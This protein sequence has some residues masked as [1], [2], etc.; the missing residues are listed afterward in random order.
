[1]SI[2]QRR[3]KGLLGPRQSNPKWVRLLCPEMPSHISR[4]F[5]SPIPELL[6]PTK[7]YSWSWTPHAFP[8]G[9]WHKAGRES[10]LIIGWWNQVSKKYLQSGTKRQKL[11]GPSPVEINVKSFTWVQKVICPVQVWRRQQARLFLAY[12]LSWTNC[13][14]RQTKTFR[15]LNYLN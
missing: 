1:M 11:I 10:K 3:Q 8:P 9:E 4:A 2:P 14:M 6:C 12:C 13:G 5:P 15:V 7:L